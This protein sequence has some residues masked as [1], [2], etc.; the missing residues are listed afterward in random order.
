[1]KRVLLFLVMIFA[2]VGCNSKLEKHSKTFYETFDTQIL[3]LEYTK[4]E[5]EF[6]KNYEFVE[7]EFRRLSKLYDNFKSFEG[8]NNVKT[9]NEKAGI[10]AV[11]VDKDL[12]NA[13]KYGIEAYDKTLGKVNIAMGSVT[14]IWKDI[15]EQNAD[16]PEN[17][18]ILPDENKLKE[19]SKHMDIKNIILDE[20]NQTVFLKDKDME[21]DLGATAKGYAVELV[22]KKLEEKGVKHGSINAGGNV[23]T[24]GT[25]G[26]G[27]K[28]WGI[29]LQNPDKNSKDYLDVMYVDGSYSI[30]TS[31][32]YERF[33]IHK[34]KIYDHIID[35]ATLSPNSKYRSVS[36]FTKDSGIADTLSTALYLST[37]EEFEQ[38]KKNYKEEFGVLWA[39][40]NEK[41]NTKN[42]D[43]ILKSKGAMSR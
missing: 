39:T 1:M 11:K 19:A 34:G 6:N 33:F 40:D 20:K 43:K 13:I 9:I 12:F 42:L 17:E 25:P 32:D 8:V 5:Q 35:P 36:I 30:V 18:T 10:E 31:G 23:R 41:E 38:I 28:T 22:A 3:Y 26:D 27:R 21:L 7:S 14:R 4:N 37:K 24:I 15:M 16:K 29:A 2:L